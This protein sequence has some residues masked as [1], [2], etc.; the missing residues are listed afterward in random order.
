MC[1]PNTEIVYLEELMLHRQSVPEENNAYIQHTCTF[2]NEYGHTGS[3]DMCELPSTC[4]LHMT[5]DR[6]IMDKH[7][8]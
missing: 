3:E 4:A 8:E 7:L 6:R 5:M 1:F 2:R